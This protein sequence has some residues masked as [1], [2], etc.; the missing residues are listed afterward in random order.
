MSDEADPNLQPIA[1]PLPDPP[2][3][4]GKVGAVMNYVKEKGGAVASTLKEK[5]AA[6]YGTTKEKASETYAKLKENERYF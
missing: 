5:S 2:K 4:E 6:V 3:A 1:D